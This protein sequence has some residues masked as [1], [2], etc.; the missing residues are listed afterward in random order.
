MAELTGHSCATPVA[1][2]AKAAGVKRL[3]LIHVNPASDEA[4]PIG[5]PTVRKIFKNAELAED[6]TVVEF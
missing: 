5:L 2:A 1:E 3:L 6:E 4:D